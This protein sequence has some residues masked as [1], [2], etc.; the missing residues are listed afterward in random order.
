MS[1]RRH[2]FEA[3]PPPPGRTFQ[4]GEQATFTK[5]ITEADIVAF[6]GLTGDFNPLHVDDEFARQSRFGSR[7]AHGM[8][9]AGL[10]SAVLGMRLPGPGAI[11]V[12]QSLS[13]KRPV[14]IGDT[15]TATA[16]VVQFHPGRRLLTLRT[17]CHN[18]RQEVVVEGE[19]VLLVAPA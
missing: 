6:A 19:A 12:S 2:D 15:I 17:T 8:L 3:S 14:L 1:Q 16:E 9:S 5:T 11:Y 7:I 18:Q 4:P 13:F 10:I